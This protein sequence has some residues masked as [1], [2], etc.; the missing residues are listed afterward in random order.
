M[1]VFSICTQSFFP[2][3]DDTCVSQQAAA[4][5]GYMMSELAPIAS[6]IIKAC[7]PTGQEK[8]FPQN[9]FS[10]MVLTGAK[11]SMVNHSQVLS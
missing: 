11:G 5:D 6:G 7:L 8:P 10:L 4:L 2:P 3:L 9:C 1:H